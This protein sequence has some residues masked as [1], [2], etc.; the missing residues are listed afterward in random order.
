MHLGRSKKRKEVG[1]DGIGLDAISPSPNG[2]LV[3]LSVFASLA[4][5]AI[6]LMALYREMPKP[7]ETLNRQKRAN[8]QYVSFA[9]VF[10][11]VD[12]SVQRRAIADIIADIGPDSAV[13]DFVVGSTVADPW[14]ASIHEYKHQLRK[15]MTTT[16]PI[17]IGK[18]SMIM[19]MVAGLIAK[20]DLPARVYV[21]GNLNAEGRTVNEINAVLGR[22]VQTMETLS[23]RNSARA[24]VS[25]YN[26][27]DT[28]ASAINAQ[29]VRIMKSQRYP[30]SD[31]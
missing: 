23:W 25:V 21:I 18:Q 22:T 29:Y 27:M 20:N 1:K 19:S 4:I 15:A 10:S 16:K 12:N 17:P 31:R 11:N 30:Y 14:V 24:P 8:A 3:V 28:T 7:T 5:L 26:Y 9:I 6:V 2:Y 13:T